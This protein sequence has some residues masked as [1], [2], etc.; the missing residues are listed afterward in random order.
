LCE[1]PPSVATSWTADCVSDVASLC[2]ATCGADQTGTCVAW[3][4]GEKEGYPGSPGEIDLALG[5]PCNG[6][7]PV[8]NHG[9]ATAP[10]NVSVYVLPADQFGGPTPPN[11]AGI[12]P[13][14]T[15][16]AISAGS[17]I[18]IPDCTNTITS[19]AA[20]LWV[21][22]PTGNPREFLTADNWAYSDPGATCGAPQCLRAAGANACFTSV[23]NTYDYQGSCPNTDQVPQWSFLTFDSV[24]PGDSSISFTVVAAPTVD[25]LSTEPAVSL[26]TVTQAAGND[27][28]QLSGTVQNCP[29]N[30]YS[31]LV[32]NGTENSV[33]LR[34]IITINPSSDGNQSPILNDWRISYSCPAGT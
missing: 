20:A 10:P 30:L 18:T 2:G 22:A 4:A 8:C 6:Q 34:L 13:C 7:I 19:Q 33:L 28:C 23:V 32:P 15:N 29:I 17:C 9:T 27:V 31:A 1:G 16:A 11:T 12:T 5:T 25:Q 3:Q 14:V 21:A 26:V 24:T